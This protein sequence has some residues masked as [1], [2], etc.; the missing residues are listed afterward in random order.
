MI[1]DGMVDDVWHHTTQLRG[2]RGQGRPGTGGLVVAWHS[3]TSDTSVAPYKTSSNYVRCR[4]KFY[5]SAACHV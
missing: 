4:S 3:V 5:T 2:H 1:A